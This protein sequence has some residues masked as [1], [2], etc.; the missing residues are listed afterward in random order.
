MGLGAIIGAGIF[1]LSGTAISLA[2]SN[3]LI[4]FVIVGIIAIMIGL[5]LGELGSILP[6][7]KGASYSYVYSAFGSEL[8]F[9]T[10][11]VLFFSYATSISAI[12]LGFG[13]YMANLLGM[14]QST[15]TAFAILLIII[16]SGVNLL[17][18][19][20]AARADSFLVMVKIIVLLALI[21]FAVYA[22]TA[23]G[24]FT[25]SN[26]SVSDSQGGIGALFAASIA[27]FFMKSSM[28]HW[29]RRMCSSRCQGE[30]VPLGNA[31]FMPSSGK[32]FTAS[33]IVMWALPPSISE[34]R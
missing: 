1:V 33:V 11:I 15:H 31:A 2:G 30:Y 16:L 12:S 7:A 20:K 27:I 25:P 10:G 9:V 17:G 3:A 26:F 24:N 19:R 29:A 18:V 23:G 4:A 22:V 13:A 32:S 34:I 21:G 6:N 5:E 14:G 28:S 8:G